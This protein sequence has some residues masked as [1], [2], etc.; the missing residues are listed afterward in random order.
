MQATG[1]K[2]TVMA[3]IRTILLY[4]GEQAEP[5]QEYRIHEIHL[6]QVGVLAPLLNGS[7][8]PIPMNVSCAFFE[9]KLTG[10]DVFDPFQ[11]QRHLR[12]KAAAMC[13]MTW[14]QRKSSLPT[15]LQDMHDFRATVVLADKF[16]VPLLMEELSVR[17]P[18][19]T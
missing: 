7:E 5:F 17:L 3:A 1:E 14:V 6:S 12:L 18:C 8:Q 10:V 16:D 19:L 2:Q 9:E 15:M 4:E 13:M 11:Q